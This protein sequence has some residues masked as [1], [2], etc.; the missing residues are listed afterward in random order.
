MA[1]VTVK[2]LGDMDSIAQ[3]AFK[4]AGDE[5]EVGAFGM[6]VIDFP[7]DSGEGA[8]PHHDHNHDDQEEVYIAWRGSG[9][10]TVDDDE[11]PLDEQT[12]VRVGVTAKRKVRSGSDGLRL[13]VIGGVAG[14]AYTRPDVFKK[15]APDP[16]AQ[17]QA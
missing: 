9:I 10:I 13:L 4:R 3:G 12:V 16:T 8:Y 5:L 15:G 17:P 7:P 2:K 6:N 1:E 11:I 14:A